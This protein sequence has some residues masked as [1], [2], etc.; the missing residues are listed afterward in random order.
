MNRECVRLPGADRSLQLGDAYPS[1]TSRMIVGQEIVCVSVMD[2][3]WPFWTSRQHLMSQFARQN[4][5]LFVDPPLTFASDYLGAGHDDRLRRKL[6]AWAKNGGLSRRGERLLLWSPPPALPFN[7]V[8]SR[9]L[10]EKL[11]AFNQEV[12]RMCLRRTLARLEF[13]SPVLWVSFNVYFGDAVVGRLGE[14]LSVY[15][16][17]D[18]ITGFPGYSPYIGEIE[19]RLAGNCDLVLTSSEVLRESKATFNAHSYF[20]PNAADVDL[21]RQALSQDG[22]EP[23]DLIGLPSPRA[24]F[25]GQVEYRFDCELLRHVAEALPGWSFILIGPVQEGNHEV[26]RL[27][28]LPNVHFLGLKRRESLPAYLAHMDVALIPYKINRLTQGIYPLK[29][30]EY[31]AAGKP[32][33]AT[34]IPSLRASPGFLY[35][36]EDGPSFVQ[37]ILQAKESDNLAARCSRSDSA[38]DHSWAARAGEISQLVARALR[39]KENDLASIRPAKAD[40]PV[41]GSLPKIQGGSSTLWS[42]VQVRVESAMSEVSHD[43]RLPL[44][45]FM[46]QGRDLYTRHGDPLKRLAYRVLGDLNIH[47]RMRAGHVVASL[48]GSSVSA[49]RIL[50]AGCGEGACAVTLAR[51]LKG[52][53]VIGVDLLESS[54]ASC[55]VMADSL[56]LRN[57]AFEQADVRDLPYEES[58]DAAVCVDVLEH[59]WEDERVLESLNRALKPGGLLVIH[60]PLRH[61]MQKR[62]IP[63]FKRHSVTGHVRDEYSREEIL[64]KV[65]AAGFVVTG[66]RRTFGGGGELAF[67]LNALFTGVPVLGVVAAAL[68]YPVALTLAYRE[69]RGRSR[70]EGNSFLVTARK[71]SARVASSNGL[72]GPMEA[73]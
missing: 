16:C 39:K 38:A 53:R 23:E 58:F 56:Q 5:V 37:A 9:V 69:L 17:T 33:V 48:L 73:G 40:I 30:H 61:Q 11:L 14:R 41:A 31:L 45:V 60:V 35:L 59:V 1:S 57:L 28:G 64:N 54:I 19:G 52:C 18:E 36:A 50:D 44:G 26:D 6:T 20:V 70:C 49:G 32:V 34:P 43:C 72:R 24:G 47:R 7:R 27:R 15:H 29:L 3:D 46:R 13:Q 55:Q 67:E 62:V 65:R 71:P 21:F 2:W 63:T 12:F 66:L 42:G 22:T 4:R 68:T 8:R 25:I 51:E 10:F